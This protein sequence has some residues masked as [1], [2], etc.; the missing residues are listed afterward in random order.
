MKSQKD[1]NMV[2]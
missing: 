1:W 2:K